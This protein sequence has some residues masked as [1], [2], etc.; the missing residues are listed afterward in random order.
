MRREHTR[1]RRIIGGTG[2]LLPPGP[3]GAPSAT[4]ITILG[5][6][7]LR[8]IEIGAGSEVV[9]APDTTA[10]WGY[11]TDLLD[12]SGN[13]YHVTAA[14]TQQGFYEPNGW[15]GRPSASLD[16]TNDFYTN[17]DAGTGAHAVAL[18][19]GNDKAFTVWTVQQFFATNVTQVVYSCGNTAASTP[20]FDIGINTT[21]N[22]FGTKNFGGVSKNLI[23]TTVSDTNRHTSDLQTDGTQGQLSLDAAAL[24]GA[25]FA[26]G[27]FDCASATVNRD[28]IGALARNTISSFMFGRFVAQITMVGVPT[29][30]EYAA[31]TA[32][33]AK[34]LA[35]QTAPMLLIA[36]DSLSTPDAWQVDAHSAYPGATISNNALA[37]QTLANYGLV[38]IARDSWSNYDSNRSANLLSAQ[39]GTNDIKNGSSGASVHTNYAS[40]VSQ[41]KAK[42]AAQKIMVSTMGWRIG[43]TGA[44]E[45]ERQAFNT[46]MRADLAGADY[47]LDRDVIITA[48]DNPALFAD[49][50]HPNAAGNTFL[51]TG[52]NGAQGIHDYAIAA[53]F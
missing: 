42:N 43:L 30:G 47:L 14:A 5:A 27:N 52:R 49:G 24:P 9:S 10:P 23:G 48:A 6:K 29:A 46:L 11:A 34:F 25:G 50:T 53:G 35:P 15:N 33:L 32:Y 20:L 28:C 13:G 21:P 4:P 37:G 19:S 26:A 31:I 1:E 2:A 39:W 41:V 51:W 7:L 22:Y 17:T 40:Y 38:N 45:T 36:G 44:Q 12:L 3:V 8:W 18:V 16:S